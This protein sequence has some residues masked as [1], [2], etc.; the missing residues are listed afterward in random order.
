MIFDGPTQE[1][2]SWRSIFDTAA[3]LYS[4]TI[5]AEFRFDL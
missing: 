5:G 3:C 4:G 1:H 2:P